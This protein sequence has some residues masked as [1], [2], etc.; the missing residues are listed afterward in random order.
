VALHE[1]P[2]RFPEPMAL[3]AQRPAVTGPAFIGAALVAER[4]R[5]GFLPMSQSPYDGARGTI[6]IP[7]AVAAM[8]RRR[9]GPHDP[10]TRA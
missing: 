8:L 7:A 4:L 1:T 6:R 5:I 2:F 3:V 10:E 9:R